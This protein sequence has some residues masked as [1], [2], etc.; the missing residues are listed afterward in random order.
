MKELQ[1]IKMYPP[2]EANFPMIM[3]VSPVLPIANASN[4]RPLHN[5]AFFTSTHLLKNLYQTAVAII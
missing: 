1:A 3:S 4:C 2:G 5:L